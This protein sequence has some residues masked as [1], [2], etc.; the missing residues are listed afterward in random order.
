MLFRVNVRGIEDALGALGAMQDAFRSR[1]VWAEIASELRKQILV[2]TARGTDADG[3]PFSPYSKGYAEYRKKHG[4]AASKPNLFFSGTMLASMDFVAREDG[5]RL[6]FQPTQA[7]NYPTGKH[8]KK[9]RVSP[10]SPAKAY[11]LQTGKKP[12][13]FFAISKADAEAAAQHIIDRINQA[14]GG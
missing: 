13:K 6:F 9:P 14:L 3:K 8:A 10:K 12:R 7:P 2:R 5:V 4:R 1:T 11:Y